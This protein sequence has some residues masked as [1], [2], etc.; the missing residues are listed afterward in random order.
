MTYI[1]LLGAGLVAVG[2]C[3]I[4][5]G[6]S[7]IEGVRQSNPDYVPRKEKARVGK[8]LEEHRKQEREFARKYAK[9]I[10][11]FERLQIK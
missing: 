3:L 11:E 6:C 5:S 7:F 9:E 1:Y 10:A 4:L 2:L 8:A